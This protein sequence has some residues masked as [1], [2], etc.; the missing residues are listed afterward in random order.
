M[1]LSVNSPWA[2]VSPIR[3]PLPQDLALQIGEWMSAYFDYGGDHKRA[4]LMRALAL[5]L[6]LKRASLFFAHSLAHRRHAHHSHPLGREDRA[7]SL[8]AYR[9]PALPPNCRPLY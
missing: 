1:L 9:R 3:C 2:V 7:D 5:A 8:V 6:A 4:Y